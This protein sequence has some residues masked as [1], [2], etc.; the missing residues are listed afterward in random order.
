MMLIMGKAMPVG[1]GLGVHKK[2]VY[3]P[4]NFVVKVKLLQ[5]IKLKKITF[6]AS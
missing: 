2:S 5:K 1:Y 4:L 3:F 6:K